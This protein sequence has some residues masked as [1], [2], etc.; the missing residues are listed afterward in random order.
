[1]LSQGAENVFKKSLKD[2]SIK[3]IKGRGGENNFITAKIS[4]LAIIM[5]RPLICL[6]I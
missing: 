5:Q 1:M 3:R 4:K 6:V 2:T